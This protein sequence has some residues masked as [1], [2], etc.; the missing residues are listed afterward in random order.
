MFFFKFFFQNYKEF[1]HSIFL[2]FNNGISEK[3]WRILVINGREDRFFIKYFIFAF[4]VCAFHMEFIEAT[5]F[6]CLYFKNYFEFYKVV[7]NV[8]SSDKT[9]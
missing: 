5:D 1:L 3:T 8:C 7:K 2:E 6:D 9:L 4:L